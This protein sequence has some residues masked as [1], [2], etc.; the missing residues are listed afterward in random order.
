MIHIRVI[1]EIAGF[2]EEHIKKVLQLKEE[3]LKKLFKVDKSKINQ[4]QQVE[5]S[6]IFSGFIEQEL[7]IVKLSDIM[8]IVLDHMPSSIEIIAPESISEDVEDL[9]PLLNDLI[10]SL[11][12]YD[13]FI[14]KLK[15][16]NIMLKK[17]S[18]KSTK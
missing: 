5:K 1:F 16:E 17:E 9:N 13:M 15:A 8:G 2:P 14:K 4:P 18:T 10:A 12:N 3:Q 6:K 11:H 7:S